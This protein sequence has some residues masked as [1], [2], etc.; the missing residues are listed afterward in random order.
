MKV[1]AP[2]PAFRP[3]AAT[4][5]PVDPVQA[6]K[7]LPVTPEPTRPQTAKPIIGHTQ[8][9]PPTPAK[10]PAFV[11]K[12]KSQEKAFGGTDKE[13]KEYIIEN[14]S[15]LLSTGVSIG[16]ALAAIASELPKKSTQKLI[17]TMSS[18]IDDGIPFWKALEQTRLY[19]TSAIA[20]IQ[21]GEESGRLPENL[22]VIGEQMHKSN[23]MAAKIRSA[24]LYPAFLLGLLFI[25]G[26]GVG[27]FLLPRLLN[28]L[29]G[30]QVQVGLITRIVIRVG[31][32]FGHYG[33]LLA[34][35]VVS[36]V[37]LMTILSMAWPP[38]KALMQATGFRIPGIKRLLFET[39]ISRFG[40]VLGTLLEAGLPVETA[41][42]SLA[43]SMVTRRYRKFAAE[44]R[45]SVE[46]GNSFAKTFASQKDRKLLPGTMRQLIVSAE[47][48]GNLSTS[49]IKVGQIYEDKA[50]I[51]ARNLET[52][53]EPIILVI[54]AV[55]VL[56]V[57]LAVILPI[58][59]LV[60]NITKH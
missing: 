8:I 32:F 48:S 19:N 44:L 52:L 13:T 53:L 15:M 23:Q 37:I 21:V 28:I 34:G 30:L 54:I 49:L 57:A 24:M 5:A 55:A 16:E 12:S 60:G 17:H 6:P 7:P 20:L 10:K 22:K 50:D 46:E 3:E 9:A 18:Q 31:T 51:T 41:L 42:Q 14:L 58:Y 29:A 27:V 59:S 47:K 56:F 25:V 4:P 45:R 38:F 26:T 33:I 39:E 43:D 35:V 36:A 2:D 1:V 11:R 40:F